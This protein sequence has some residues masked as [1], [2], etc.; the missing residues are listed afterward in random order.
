MERVGIIDI[1][2]NVDVWKNTRK[3]KFWKKINLLKEKEKERLFIDRKV[4][5]VKM[6]KW[7]SCEQRHALN[8]K[9]N[10]VKKFS[11]LN[12]RRKEENWMEG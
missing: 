9:K 8:V 4:V 7:S 5:N 6:T 3:K 11:M 1:R 10:F 2:S 12:W